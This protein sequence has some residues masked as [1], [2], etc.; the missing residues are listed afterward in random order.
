MDVSVNPK[1]VTPSQPQ[2]RPT[3]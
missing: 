1:T 3:P 2:R